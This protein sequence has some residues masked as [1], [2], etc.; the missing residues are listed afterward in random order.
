[1]VDEQLA[2]SRP[3]LDALPLRE[4]YRLSSFADLKDLATSRW[5]KC[6]RGC[7]GR[8]RLKAARNPER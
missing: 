7:K 8:W 4:L 6:G 5:R 1:M 3:V 2:R